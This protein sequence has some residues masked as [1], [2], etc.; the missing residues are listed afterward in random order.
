MVKLGALGGHKGDGNAKRGIAKLVSGI[1]FLLLALGAWA[2]ALAGVAVMR[3]TVG[4]NVLG[5]E[6][7]FTWWVIFFELFV[8]LAALAH[9]IGA[10][11]GFMPIGA[12]AIAGILAVVTALTMLE[13]QRWNSARKATGHS[14]RF[15]KGVTTAF[16]GFLAVSA[17][18]ALLILILGN[19]HDTA[20][21][22][23]TSHN[24]YNNPTTQTNYP[25]TQ[26]NYPSTGTAAPGHTGMVHATHTEP[27]HDRVNVV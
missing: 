20:K 10:G 16:A 12:S 11:A 25:N 18:N 22:V 7:D 4:E 8:L 24:T 27:T 6:L 23:S 1:P 2:V 9:I 17:L 15:G 14:D 5:V 19:Q 26:A 3:K 13:T 21:G